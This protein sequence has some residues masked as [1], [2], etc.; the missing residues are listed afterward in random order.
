MD[1]L[2]GCTGIA[3]SNPATPSDPQVESIKHQ[4]WLQHLRRINDIRLGV[5]KGRIELAQEAAA[6]LQAARSGTDGSIG[7]PVSELP[8]DPEEAAIL[9]VLLASDNVRM[10][11]QV[12]SKKLRL[13]LSEKTIYTKL[14][15]LKDKGLICRPA[16]SRKGACLTPD[17]R[18]L[19]RR[20]ASSS[21]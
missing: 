12:I 8:L 7:M 11:A 1:N 20:L 5:N 3:T 10:T 21:E 16:S 2:G 19:A 9:E 18:T 14:K 4:T 6:I 13:S 17:G 15:S